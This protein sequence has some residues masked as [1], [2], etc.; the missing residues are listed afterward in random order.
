M[1]SDAERYWNAAVQME[2]APWH[3]LGHWPVTLTDSRW[4]D[5]NRGVP[6][7]EIDTSTP[8]SWCGC[9]CGWAPSRRWTPETQQRRLGQHLEAVAE[10]GFPGSTR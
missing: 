7:S 4:D 10:R 8:I 6:L 1:Q 2:A 5:L 9:H 3:Q